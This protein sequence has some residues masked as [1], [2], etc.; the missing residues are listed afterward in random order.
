MTIISHKY[1]IIFI[2]I[3]KCAGT[4]IRT[5]IIEND[6]DAIR[7]EHTSYCELLEK[8]PIE[9]KSYLI[10]TVVR[11]V[12][13]RLVS[14]YHYIKQTPGLIVR[15]Y[16]EN[17]NFKEFIY[18]EKTHVRLFVWIKDKDNNISSNINIFHHN[19]N[20]EEKINELFLNNNINLTLSISRINSSNHKNFIEYYDTETLNIVKTFFKDEIEYFNFHPYFRHIFVSYP[21][22]G[23][24]LIFNSY[25]G[26]DNKNINYICYNYGICNSVPCNCENRKLI[27]KTHDAD[28]KLEYEPT[29]YYIVMLRK[30]P[31][32]NIEAYL[33]LRL[34][35]T[36]PHTP[37]WKT[38][39]LKLDFENK[40]HLDILNENT[41]QFCR[42]YKNMLSKYKEW[43]KYK[44]VNIIYTEDLDNIEE[45]KSTLNTFYRVDG[46]KLIKN[47][48]NSCNFNI[49]II[50]DDI[51]NYMIKSKIT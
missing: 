18:K 23:S 21:R 16:V 1:K 12:Y 43:S 50:D 33:R 51:Y 44:N 15:E 4:A 2:H 6:P 37:A 26:L 46:D 13:D 28:L 24:N 14:Q 36:I 9:T 49:N 34:N 38:N 39:T 35:E 40:I 25:L 48:V 5:A 22:C 42:Y 41:Q 47:I 29:N 7:L 20:F 32:K 3:P 17:S 31:I 10:F 45:I 8:Y 27:T 19:D 11:N 30:D